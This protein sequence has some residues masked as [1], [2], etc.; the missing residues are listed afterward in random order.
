[1]KIGEYARRRNHNPLKTN[2]LLVIQEV[3]ADISMNDTRFL[4]KRSDGLWDVMERSDILLKIVSGVLEY[5]SPSKKTNPS[6]SPS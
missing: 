5:S 2:K 3:L 4:T 6:E 1:M